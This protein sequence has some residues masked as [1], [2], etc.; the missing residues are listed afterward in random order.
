MKYFQTNEA[1]IGINVAKL[2]IDKPY[3]I[4]SAVCKLV[5]K[6][7]VDIILFDFTLTQ[8]VETKLEN[9]FEVVEDIKNGCIVDVMYGQYQQ[10][11]FDPPVVIIF[12]N[13]S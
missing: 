1:K 2:P 4:R 12:T 13:S 7:D 6:Q 5:K 8:G 11:V 3:P 10:A 9:L